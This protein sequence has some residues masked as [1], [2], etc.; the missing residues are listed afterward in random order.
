MTENKPG[1]LDFIIASQVSEAGIRAFSCVC[2]VSGAF[3][4]YYLHP[5]SPPKRVFRSPGGRWTKH[6]I[7]SLLSRKISFLSSLWGLRDACDAGTLLITCTRLPLCTHDARV[8]SCLGVFNATFPSS[9][10]QR[11]LPRRP[12]S[13]RRFWSDPAAS[14]TLPVRVGAAVSDSAD[15]LAYFQSSTSCVLPP[16][17]KNV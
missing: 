2:D 11:G 14:L 12:E 6:L 13:A 10:K 3:K 7:C 8:K 15:K 16:P 5:S 4:C 1:I 17:K 9:H